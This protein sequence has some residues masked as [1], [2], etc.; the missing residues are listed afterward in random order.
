MKMALLSLLENDVAD[1]LLGIV[2]P[3]DNDVP[4]TIANT[5]A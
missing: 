4:Q 2:L 5:R 1:L 3:P